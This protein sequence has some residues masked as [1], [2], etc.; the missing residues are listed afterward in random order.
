M[1]VWN[2]V[3]KKGTSKVALHPKRTP[4]DGMDEYG[5]SPLHY[6]ALHGNL[7][8]VK[9]FITNGADINMQDDSGMTPLQFAVQE[10]CQSVIVFLLSLNANPN[11]LDVHGNGSLWTAV[12]TT[13]KMT[14]EADIETIKLLLSHGANAHQE[15]KHGRSPYKMA[16]EIAHGLEKPFENL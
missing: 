5:R 13:K 11:L 12:M 14:F 2:N 3:K 15:N 10:K 9:T 8:E 1:Q 6:A 4:R 16:L 7:D